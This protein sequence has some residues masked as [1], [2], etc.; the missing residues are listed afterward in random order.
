METTSRREALGYAKSNSTKQPMGFSTPEKC[1]VLQIGADTVPRFCGVM[2]SA[3]TD[4]KQAT[5]FVLSLASTPRRSFNS[6]N[7]DISSRITRLL[8]L[9]ELTH[10][11]TPGIAPGS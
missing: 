3:T 7:L 6:P 1:P 9:V 11:F 10:N 4:P 5:P 2:V 8:E